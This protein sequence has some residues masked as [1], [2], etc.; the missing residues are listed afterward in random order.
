MNWKDWDDLTQPG[1][2]HKILL[3]SGLRVLSIV[4]ST[5][6]SGFIRCALDLVSDHLYV[7]QENSRTRL[8]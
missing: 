7:V 6:R 3:K 2:L 8:I 1:N 5:D 4:V